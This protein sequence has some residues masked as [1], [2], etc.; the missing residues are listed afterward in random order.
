[1]AEISG[2]LG[3][4]TKRQRIA[5]LAVACAMGAMLAGCEE[6]SSSKGAAVRQRPRIVATTG[7]VADIVRRI[8][9]DSVGV[10]SLMAPGVDPHLYKASEGDIQRLGRADAIFYNGLHLEG[11]MGEIFHKLGRRRPVVAVGDAVP[12]ERLRDPPGF[13]GNYDPHIWFDVQLWS[14]TTRPIVAQLGKLLPE[15]EGAFARRAKK[16]RNELGEL[17]RWV[18]KRIETI[19]RA[20]RVLVTAH[21]AFGYFGRRYDIQVVGLQGVSTASRAGLKDVERVVALV[22]ERK[23]PAIFVETSVP[24]RTIEAVQQ[25]CRKRGHQV[26]IGGKLYSDSMGTAG[27]GADDYFGMVRHNVNTIVEALSAR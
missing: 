24:R 8:G 13:S 19:P 1:M 20:Q 10:E 6:S 4:R 12:R 17:D 3:V 22:V 25:G 18:G 5:V 23:I 2:E 15:H 14:H 11:K 27:S 9:G 26:V 21:D 16:L 7:I